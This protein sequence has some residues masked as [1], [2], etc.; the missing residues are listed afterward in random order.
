MPKRVDHGQRRD[1]IAA[2]LWRVATEEGLRAATLR[3]I[4]AEAGIS[5]NLVQYY[6]PTKAEMV[7]YGLQR[8]VELAAVRVQAAAA[9][10]LPSADPR[11][12]LRACLL[13]LLPITQEGHR[14][15]AVYTAY[16]SHALADPGIREL[17]SR[18]P[19]D[20][21]G[22]LVPALRKA[23]LPE[24]ADVEHEIHA[25]LATAAGLASAVLLGTHSADD[26]VT[27]IDYRLTAL[28]GG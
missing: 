25:L 15:S 17:M 14:L 8:L 6:F 5:M 7:H 20:L 23:A 12:I 27:L 4:A 18:L 24:W 3:R 1:E 2:A 26:A 10:V 28:F 11:A 13:G 22:Q 21:A 9:T 16:L 19:R